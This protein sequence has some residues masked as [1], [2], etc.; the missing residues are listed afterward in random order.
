MS[1]ASYHSRILVNKTSSYTS[2]QAN[3]LSIPVYVLASIC[4]GVTTYVS[5]RLKRRAVCLIH[6]PLLVISGYAIAVGTGHKGAG[7]FAMFLVGAGVY[8]FNTVL[9]T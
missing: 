9:V 4:T 8:S 1:S 7:F 3:Y 6:S 2:L 5:D